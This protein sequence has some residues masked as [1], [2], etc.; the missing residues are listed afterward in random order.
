VQGP[1]V[2]SVA[3]VAQLLGAPL[4]RADLVSGR[5]ARGLLWGRPGR[6]LAAAL[7]LIGIAGH[8]RELAAVRGADSSRRSR[9]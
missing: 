9:S 2:F 3:D 1:V 7:A 8:H 4:R 5:L 6:L